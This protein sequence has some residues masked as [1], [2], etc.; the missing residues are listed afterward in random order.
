MSRC[1]HG[2]ALRS[3]AIAA[4]LL[5]LVLS[6]GVLEAQSADL[7]GW[8]DSFAVVTPGPH[9]GKSGIWVAFAGHH[10]RDLWTVPIRV[11]VISLQRFAGGLTPP[12]RIAAM[13]SGAPHGPGAGSVR[14]RSAGG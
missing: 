2:G 14:P 1:R 11:P 12:R 10:Y 13:W 7:P 5:G 3:I 4:G 6:D 9:Y 8:A